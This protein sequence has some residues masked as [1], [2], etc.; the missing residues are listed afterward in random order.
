MF[1]I[2][3]DGSF[4]VKPCPTAGRLAS[5]QKEVGGYFALVDAGR[6]VGYV[7]E[8]GAQHANPLA[9]FVLDYVGRNPRAYRLRGPL[10][11]LGPGERGLT[12]EEASALAQLCDFFAHGDAEHAESL[13]AELRCLEP[14]FGRQ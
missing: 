3:P 13:H 12:A 4:A 11:I 6:F 1:V 14:E 9:D 5:L 2:R 10:V 7:N 8:D